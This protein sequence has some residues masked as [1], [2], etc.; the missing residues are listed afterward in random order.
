MFLSIRSEKQ[1]NKKHTM[2]SKIIPKTY[3]RNID[4][5][6]TVNYKSKAEKSRI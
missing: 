1:K 4:K 3:T 6:V 5:M 2:F